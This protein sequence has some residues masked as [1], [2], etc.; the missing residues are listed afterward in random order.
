MNATGN[1][2]I[3]VAAAI[4]RDNAL[5]LVRHEKDGRGYWMLPGGGVQW[6]EEIETALRREWVEETG[7][8]IAV[9]DLLLVK[10]S[11]HPAGERHL[12]HMIFEGDIVGGAAKPSEDPRVVEA[13]WVPLADFATL[14][15]RPDI[16]PDLLKLL[17]SGGSAKHRFLRNSWMD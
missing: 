8:E 4:V 6:G 9:G 14:D 1:P 15:F 5:F 17:D 10:E 3:R 16:V 13:C 11:I 2:R 7:F 12:V